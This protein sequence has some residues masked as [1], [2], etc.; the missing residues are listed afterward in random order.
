MNACWYTQSLLVGALIAPHTSLV[1]AKPLYSSVG[2]LFLQ[3]NAITHRPSDAQTRR[4][5][6][7]HMHAL[8]CACLC[9]GC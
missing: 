7:L 6:P 3:C 9:N 1:G 4:A 5:A 2:S 8:W